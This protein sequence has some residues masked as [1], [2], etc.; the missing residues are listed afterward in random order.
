MP[1]VVPHTPR[2]RALLEAQDWIVS[3]AQVMAHG[4]TRHAIGHRLGTGTWQ[5]LLP[6]VYVCHPGEASRR[7]KLVGALLY[8][9]EHS[10]IDA[11][12]ACHFYGL[13]AIAP[14]DNV[15]HVVV[16]WGSPA[17][18]HGYVLVRRTVRPFPVVCTSRL[19]YL[20]PASA[21]IAACRLATSERRA[22]AI[23]S[24]AVQRRIVTRGRLWLRTRLVHP[25]AQC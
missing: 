15:V 8:A 23:L 25:A 1:S 18:S 10:A 19:R 11:A 14:D 4:F 12:D 9:G 2:F 17:R 24:D 5:V 20:E 3:R 13:R 22:I 6:S 16:P 21:V 7:Q